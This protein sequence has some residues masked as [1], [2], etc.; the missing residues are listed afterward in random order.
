ML[1]AKPSIKKTSQQKLPVIKT[2][3]KIKEDS[4]VDEDIKEENKKE[5][6]SDEDIFN[7]MGS[8][9]LKKRE[10]PLTSMNFPGFSRFT[11]ITRENFF[12]ETVPVDNDQYKRITRKHWFIDPIPKGLLPRLKLL[13]TMFKSE[14][15]INYYKKTP[16]RLSTSIDRII[17]Y[18]MGYS[19]HHNILDKYAMIFYYICHQITYD[20]KG[21]NADNS[22]LKDVF[23]TGLANNFQFVKIF[24]YMCRK[25]KL[26]Y[27]RIS[28]FCKDMVLP[29]FRP[30]MDID[31]FNHCWN[32]IPIQNEWYFVDVTFG[33]GGN[34]PKSVFL[35]EYFNP[36][37]FLTPPEYLAYSHKPYEDNWELTEKMIIDKEFANRKNLYLGIFYQKVYLHDIELVSHEFPIINSL[38]KNLVV[39]IG[40]QDQLIQASLLLPN[41]KTKL[42]EVKYS[43]NPK[44]N[45]IALEPNFP[46]NGEYILQIISRSIDSTDLV[47]NP[48]LSYKI[49]IDDSGMELFERL[50]GENKTSERRP[51]TSKPGFKGMSKT[52]TRFFSS[53]KPQRLFTDV[54]NINR[55][56]KKKICFDN[57][58]AYLLE[59]RSTFIKIGNESEIKCR[60]R[61]VIAVYVLDNKKFIPLKKRDDGIW[62]GLVTVETK[63]VSIVSLKK[64]NGTN[65]YT[66]VFHLNAIPNNSK[67]MKNLLK[68]NK[69]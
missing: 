64:F 17:K 48:L 1:K 37:Y 31:E 16:S 41:M 21:K 62:Q 66:E 30:G 2:D 58:G 9:E 56:N 12:N 27:R 26:R 10:R 51:F 19:N 57:E 24:E 46:G 61:G 42:S 5:I 36:F 50:K 8:S 28:G 6:G 63:D 55:N 45:V 33:S 25:A 69:I 40:I 53:K 3:T 11:E 13:A 4:K 68:K 44:T 20:V 29:S 14:D 7:T 35:T 18:L 39:K 60:V 67:V 59:P 34:K 54:S 49:I 23:K 22:D 47:Y 38:T 52:L 32:A 15:F 43:S 65:V